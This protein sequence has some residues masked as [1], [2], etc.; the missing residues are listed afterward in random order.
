MA[1]TGHW[2]AARE[3]GCGPWA[4]RGGKFV[5]LPH[6]RVFGPAYRGTMKNPSGPGPRALRL[7]LDGRL[8]DR[9]RVS[10]A[11]SVLW[12]PA[13]AVAIRWGAQLDVGEDVVGW[14]D[15]R[16]GRTV[17]FRRGV[18]RA[19]VEGRDGLALSAPPDWSDGNLLLPVDAVALAADARWSA[20]FRLGVLF[21]TRPDPYLSRFRIFLD[22]GHG[23]SESGACFADGSLEKDAN[24]E[25]ARRLA[26]LL[27]ASGAAVA[28]SRP[29]DRT[30]PLA[31]RCRAAR[32]FRADLAISIHHG[33]PTCGLP[34][35]VEAYY[36]RTGDSR[37]LAAALAASLGRELHL[38]G[39]GVREAHI[40][41]LT[42]LACPAALV[43]TT[44]PDAPSPR[45]A[46][47]PAWLWVRESMALLQGLRAFCSEAHR[48]S[49][50][51][52]APPV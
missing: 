43:Q 13:A 49:V 31:R 8:L 38:V 1:D 40:G 48:D 25:V 5:L 35:S 16:S 18:A 34:G 10:V 50:A 51:W 28:L 27:R 4:K 36:G 39:Q 44:F 42:C 37:R 47:G 52:P 24:L 26:M 6:T 15:A 30:R 12:V 7:V 23:G 14:R 20:D 3:E 9:T 41:I 22:P 19:E 46:R 29:G 11:G 45:A 17:V 21:L 33:A 32:Q 2:H